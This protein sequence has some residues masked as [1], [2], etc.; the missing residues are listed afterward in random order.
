MDTPVPGL[1]RW[2]VRATGLVFLAT[3]VRLLLAARLPLLDDEAYYWL[4]SKHLA[5]GYLDHPPGI[6]LAIAAA[7]ALFGDATWAI[8]LPSILSAAGSA[9]LSGKLVWEMTQDPSCAYRAVVLLHTVPLFSLGAVI[10]APDPLLGFFWML[11]SWALWRAVQ[12]QHRFWLLVGAGVGLGL[13]SKYTMIL[14]LPAAAVLARRDLRR[15]G[16]LSAAFVLALLLFTPNLVWNAQHGW[17]AFRYAF[18]RAPWVTPDGPIRNL[19]LYAAAVLLYLSPVLGILLLVAP[20][21]L[22]APTGTFLRWLTAPTLL[23]VLTAAGAAKAK[24]HYILPAALTGMVALAQVPVDRWRRAW[25]AGLVIGGGI[26]ALTAGTAL[27]QAIPA[28]DLYGW[29]QVAQRIAALTNGRPTLLIATTYQEGAQLAY[30]TRYPV[31]VLPGDHAFGQWSPLSRWTGSEGLVVHDA[32]SRPAGGYGRW[33]G[34]TER[35]PMLQVSGP[36]WVRRFIFVRCMALRTPPTELA[37]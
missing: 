26:C 6:A 10:A 17:A 14:L 36:G 28:P 30:A 11:S 13:E 8:R 3:F 25:R 22:P 15:S 33:C 27:A 29:P 2:T 31:T 5:W 37:D 23:A 34:H 12:G 9:W 16:Y 24:P 21:R 7:T 4:W 19:L 35:L 1:V 32:R 18:G 20:W